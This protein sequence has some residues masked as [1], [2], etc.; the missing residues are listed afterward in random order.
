MSL[1][2]KKAKVERVI[3]RTI[4]KEVIVEKE[5]IK[6]LLG[7]AER[8]VV[9]RAFKEEPR[10]FCVGFAIAPLTTATELGYY[11]SCAQ[12]FAENPGC[13]VETRSLWKIGDKF[14]KS[15]NV[16]PVNIKIESKPKR[17]KGKA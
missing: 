11:H 8:V 6:Y 1:F 7:N 15:L 10:V 3:E 12:A 14:V 2:T 17:G 16:V 4:E 9:Y 13:K 5:V